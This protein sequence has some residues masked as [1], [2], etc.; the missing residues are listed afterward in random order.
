M[1]DN[2]FNVIY[3]D[4]KTSRTNFLLEL[5][6]LLK[7][8]DFKSFFLSCSLEFQNARNIEPF[9]EFRVLPSTDE[10]NNLKTIEVIAEIT[11]SKNYSYI[12]VDDIDYLSN[13]CISELGK[14]N[15]KKIVTCLTHNTGKL[16]KDSNFFS[17]EDITID[18]LKDYMTSLKRDKKINSI[19]K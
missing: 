18:S 17:V 3:G 5:A 9:D 11:E 13:R 7:N 15:V 16:P 8:N 2:N 12:I 10:F 6:F 1:F 19:L 4:R 14:I